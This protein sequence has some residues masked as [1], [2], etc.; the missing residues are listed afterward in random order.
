MEGTPE[1]RVTPNHHLHALC[2]PGDF[3]AAGTWGGTHLLPSQPGPTGQGAAQMHFLKKK[4]KTEEIKQENLPKFR[5][6]SKAK[7]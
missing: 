7:P 1:Q 5:E 4:R 6:K 2:S 3:S